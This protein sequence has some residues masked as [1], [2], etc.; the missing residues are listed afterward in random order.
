[1]MK[2]KSLL[3][4]CAVLL[5]GAG[6]SSH[7]QNEQDDIYLY[8][9]EVGG[10]YT[11]P[12]FLRLHHQGAFPYLLIRDGKSG[13]LLAPLGVDCQEHSAAIGSGTELGDPLTMTETRERVPQKAID[14]AIVAVCQQQI[15]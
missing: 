5:G 4:L 1:M 11:D 7:A 8:E 10:P 13:L 15:D 3:P 9:Q 12:W 6:F 2:I 14:L